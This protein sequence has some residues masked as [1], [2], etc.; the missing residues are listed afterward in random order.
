VELQ[1]QPPM[2]GEEGVSEVCNVEELFGEEGLT[3]RLTRGSEFASVGRLALF[4]T[5]GETL[6]FNRLDSFR[7]GQVD[8]KAQRC[9]H[10]PVLLVGEGS[11]AA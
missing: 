5:D 1:H 9:V 6:K 8:R 3:E 11:H 4:T 7:R 2:E 10:A